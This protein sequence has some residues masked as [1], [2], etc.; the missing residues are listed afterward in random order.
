MKTIIIL[1][2]LL[3]AFLGAWYKGQLSDFLAPP[4]AHGLPEIPALAAPESLIEKVT[5]QESMEKHRLEDHSRQANTK[6]FID[7]GKTARI[8]DI[9][10]FKSAEEYRAWLATRGGQPQERT[11]ID[12]LLNLMARGKWE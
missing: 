10:N 6:E 2:T 8:T 4:Q 11:E 9:A 12:K 3:I 5:F 1:A 7:T